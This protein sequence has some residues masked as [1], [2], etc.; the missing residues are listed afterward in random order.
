MKGGR[1]IHESDK[2]AKREQRE[3]L[4]RDHNME[5][6]SGTGGSEISNITYENASMKSI[7]LYVNL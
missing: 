2:E 4:E 7:T 5:D 1:E 6:C 3:I